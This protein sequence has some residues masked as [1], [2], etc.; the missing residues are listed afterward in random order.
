MTETK[1]IRVLLVD[2]HPLVLEG[3]NARLES[4]EGIGVV[5]CAGNG[6]EALEAAKRLQPDVVLMDISMP[7]MNG[8]EAAQRF[9]TDYPQIRVL[10]LSMH[11][12]REYIVKMIQ[13]GAAGYVLKDVSSGEL[14]N[15]IRTVHNGGTYFSASASQSLFS[16]F[17]QP[18]A[19]TV[20]ED[21][22]T[23][24]E[25]TVLKLLAEGSSN[26]EIARTLDISVRTVETHRQNIKQKLN[27]QTA[28]GLTKYAIEH[29]LVEL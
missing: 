22:L 7:V 4:E 13:S 9:H 15:A 5:G 8:L 25:Q 18:P 29:R 12:K 28:A 14:I 20:S 1:V 10:I 6:Q 27:I 23:Q 11:D 2:D 3:I 19:E 17:D 24:R 16:S 26:K 21:K